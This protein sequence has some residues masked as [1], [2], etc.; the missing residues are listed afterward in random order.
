MSN[1]IWKM[2][3][4]VKEVR[5]RYACDVSCSRASRAKKKALG[6]VDNGLLSHYKKVSDYCNEVLSRNPK[7]TRKFQVDR[8]NEGDPW[9]LQRLYVC[10]HVL[11]DGWREGYRHVIGVDRCFLK[12]YL[13]VELLTTIGR[14]GNSQMFPIV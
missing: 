5:E 12:G 13:K 4:F 7:A 10:F 1:P 2:K 14:D 9:R 3:E 8:P 11:A 6:E